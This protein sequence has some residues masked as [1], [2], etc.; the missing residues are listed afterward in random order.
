MRM[1]FSCL[2]GYGSLH[3]LLLLSLAAKKAGHEVAFAIGG[4]RRSTLATHLD[5]IK[6][7][8]TTSYSSPF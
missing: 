4:E 1:L 6:A 7:N 3:P 8:K 2:A 5:G